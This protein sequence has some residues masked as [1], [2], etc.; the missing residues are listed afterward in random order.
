MIGRKGV[1]ALAMLLLSAALMASPALGKCSKE[2]RTFL[3]GRKTTCLGKCATGTKKEKRTCKKIFCQP[4][5]KSWTKKCKKAPAPP[6][7]ATN[8]GSP[9]GAFADF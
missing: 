2:C 8:C 5:F 1:T 4:A 9:S 3:S 7:V 6:T